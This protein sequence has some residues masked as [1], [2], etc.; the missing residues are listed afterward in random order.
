MNN[1]KIAI[2]DSGLQ[3]NSTIYK[4]NFIDGIQIG[5]PDNKLDSNIEDLNGHGTY[6]ANIITDVN[7]D[8]QLFIV[9]I[10]NKGALANHESLIKALEYLLDIDVKI[11]NLSL[12]VKYWSDI[13]RLYKLCKKLVAQGKIIISALANK[14]ESSFPAIFDNVI[15]VRGIKNSRNTLYKYNKKHTIQCECDAD[16]IILPGINSKYGLFMGNSKATALFT[17]HISKIITGEDYFALQE[18]IKNITNYEFEQK[19]YAN[20]PESFYDECGEI[21]SILTHRSID[22]SCKYDPN[23]LFF[24]GLNAQNCCKF[25]E[26]CEQRWNKILQTPIFYKDIFSV[27]Y[28]YHIFSR[29]GIQ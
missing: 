11:I 26:L 9:K 5:Y 8:I 22:F 6:C 12:S 29:G 19:I 2:V 21:L 7:P 1:T 25:L 16:P 15:G 13:D 10:L 23:Y 18:K 24:S 3:T 17:G 20:A 28:L 27:E 14:C 4:Y